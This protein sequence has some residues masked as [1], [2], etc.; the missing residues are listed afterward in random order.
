MNRPHPQ[1]VLSRVRTAAFTLVEL[2]VVIGII[3]LLIAIL[4]PALASARRSAARVAC[5]SN[6]RQIGI[7]TVAYSVDNK[8]YVPEYRR[9]DTWNRDAALTNYTY[10]TYTLSYT[11]DSG[12]TVDYGSQAGR[13]IVKKY[14][15]GTG[16][17]SPDASGKILFCPASPDNSLFGGRAN[18]QYNA[19]P[20]FVEGTPG[21]WNSTSTTRWKKLRDMPKDRALAND[22]IYDQG[23]VGH[24]GKN[25]N[26]GWNLLFPDGHVAMPTSKDVFD[27]L[28]G[29][30]VASK[31][32]R[33]NDYLRVLELIAD[34]QDPK[35]NNGQFAWGGDRYYPIVYAKP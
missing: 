13:L 33:L 32:E 23:P 31:W 14:L 17:R 18:Y 25:G 22:V 24:W 9:Y 5:A 30:P 8:G 34:N 19:H 15:G 29:R 35:I 7:A 6:L 4:L 28:K 10:Y 3:A 20:A 11:F 26:A 21:G 2:L 1:R 16:D 12:T 27:S